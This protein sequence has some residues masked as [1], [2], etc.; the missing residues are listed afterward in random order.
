M[1]ERLDNEYYDIARQY[2][3]STT[4]INI[5]LKNVSSGLQLLGP[6][7]RRI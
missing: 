1:F 2:I 7:S 5:E 3:Y 6:V 4:L